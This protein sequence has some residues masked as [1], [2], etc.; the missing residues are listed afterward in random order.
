VEEKVSMALRIK[1]LS[2]VAG[3]SEVAKRSIEKQWGGK[4]TE[5]ISGPE[6][7]KK[8]TRTKAD[9]DNFEKTFFLKL[10]ALN[11]EIVLSHKPLVNRKFVLD[12]AIIAPMIALEL[13]GWQFHGKYIGAHNK[14]RERQ[15]LLES[16]GWS[17]LRFTV[18]H[19][20]KIDYCDG[21]IKA[22]LDTK[23]RMLRLK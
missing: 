1:S 11:P 17:F 19:T 4:S 18:T 20:K 10:Q 5:T 12:A 6:S 21:L 8:D 14:D 13:D 15:N 22:T 7:P 3:M 2:E 23:K 16:M 9:Y